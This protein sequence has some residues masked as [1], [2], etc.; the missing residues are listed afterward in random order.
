MMLQHLLAMTA[1]LAGAAWTQDGAV[2]ALPKFQ[3]ADVHAA[4]YRTFPFAN[5]GVLR[6]SRIWRE[7][8]DGAG[9]TAVAGVR[10]V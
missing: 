8:W 7:Q 1:L 4:P 5:G 10:P 2:K 3:A 9:R 6:G